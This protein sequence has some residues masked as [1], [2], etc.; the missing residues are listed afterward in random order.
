MQQAV[1]HILRTQIR[2]NGAGRVDGK[3]VLFFSSLKISLL[4]LVFDVLSQC[5]ANLVPARQLPHGIAYSN[6]IL[7]GKSLQ[8]QPGEITFQQ[9]AGEKRC[10]VVVPHHCRVGGMIFAGSSLQNVLDA[11]I[12]VFQHFGVRIWFMNQVI[13]AMYAV[14]F[15]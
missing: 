13:T 11:L 2:G 7:I 10:S 12:C 14:A 15:R 6:S 5:V 8:R 4:H 9:V 1:I 3:T